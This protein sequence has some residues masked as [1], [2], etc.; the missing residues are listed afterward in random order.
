MFPTEPEAEFSFVGKR[1]PGPKTKAGEKIWMHPTDVGRVNCVKCHDADPIIFT[2]NIAAQFRD[3]REKTK[4][5]PDDPYFVVGSKLPFASPEWQNREHFN[6]RN[7]CTKCHKIGRGADGG[8]GFLFQKA[9]GKSNYARNH[10]AA[11]AWMPPK[12]YQH[13]TTE[14]LTQSIKR[15]SDCCNRLGGRPKDC[16]WTR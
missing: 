9:I 3:L 4:S 11:K 12:S 8:C 1:L 7:L 5:S 10:V 6:E 16:N 2:P 13:Y 15:I 14:S